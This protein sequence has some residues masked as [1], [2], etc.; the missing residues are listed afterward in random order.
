[1]DKKTTEQNI[2]YD[3]YNALNLMNENLGDAYLLY[4]FNPYGTNKFLI[5]DEYILDRYH[6]SCTKSNINAPA[7]IE[8]EGKETQVAFEQSI[9]NLNLCLSEVETKLSAPN[10]SAKD[11]ECLLK[12]K[13]YLLCRI[14]LTNIFLKQLR[15]TKNIFELYK[16]LQT[17]DISLAKYFDTTYEQTMDVQIAI[18]ACLVFMKENEKQASIENK[19]LIAKAKEIIQKNQKQVE[20]QKQSEIPRATQEAPIFEK[21]KE[22]MPKKPKLPEKQKPIQ[23]TNTEQEVER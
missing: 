16:Q 22:F 12:L 9:Q 14:E 1:M 11:K 18:N 23:K 3:I 2:N 21:A 8:K 17:L 20:E 10:L 5:S 7:F 15:K 19:K 13:H 4:G 6:N